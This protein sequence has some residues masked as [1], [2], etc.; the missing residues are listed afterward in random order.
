MRLSAKCFVAP[1]LLVLLVGGVP[2]GAQVPIYTAQGFELAGSF[3]TTGAAQFG[4]SD[5]ADLY[6]QGTPYWTTTVAPPSKPYNGDGV[7]ADV[8]TSVVDSGSQAISLTRQFNSIDTRWGPSTFYYTPYEAVS[9][10]TP[11][12]NINWD[13]DVASSGYDTVF[14]IELNDHGGAGNGRI[15]YVGVDSSGTVVDDHAG[16]IT[17]TLQSVSTNSWH[18][19]ELQADFATDTYSIFVD[20]STIPTDTFTFENL[21]ITAFTD[22][23]L[24]SYSENGDPGATGVAYFDNYVIS[25]PEPSAAGVLMIAGGTCLMLR[26]RST[27]FAAARWKLGSH[28]VL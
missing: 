12:V 13:M 26:R 1:V 4:D 23:S 6:G 25:V 22:A 9:D 16:G 2:A 5:Q 21:G 18:H 19:Y 27:I 7:A 20:N 10:N 11:I 14:G 24:V 17:A 3:S 28:R 8:E 15:A